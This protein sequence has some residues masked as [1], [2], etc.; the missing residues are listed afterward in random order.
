MSQLIQEYLLSIERK[1]DFDSSLALRAREDIE[2]YLHELAADRNLGP[3]DAVLH[4]I[5]GF[6]DSDSV[7]RQYAASGLGRQISQTWLSLLLA[8]TGAFVAMRLRAITI[9]AEVSELFSAL[10]WADRFA[11]ATC[12]CFAAI[13]RLGYSFSLPLQVC[14]PRTAFRI[15]VLAIACSVAFGLTRAALAHEAISTGWLALFIIVTAAAEMIA[16]VVAGARVRKMDR[17]FMQAS[18]AG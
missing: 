4:A 3:Q 5:A 1:L 14:S 7:A 13:G 17:Y 15:S 2:E 16:L 6:G 9:E 18:A 10:L 8:M 12:L 11:L